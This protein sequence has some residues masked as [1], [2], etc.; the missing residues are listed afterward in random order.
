MFTQTRG[1]A[2][3][4]DQNQVL[5]TA[6]GGGTWRDVTP[7]DFISP[8]EGSTSY[9]L[10]PFFLDEST[11]WL[12]PFAV[13]V[14]TLYHT[15]D[16][17]QTWT[18]TSPPFENASFEFLDQNL[19]YALGDLGAGAGSH[20][21]AIYRTLDGGTTWTM[22]FTHEPGEIKSLP[23]GGSKNGITFRG[24]DH[25]W[26]GGAI[27]M[28]DYFYLHYT[29]DG[30]A[31]WAQETDIALPEEFSGSMLDVWQPVFLGASSAFLPVRAYP[32]GGGIYLLIFRSDD[33]DETWTYRGFVAGGEAVDFISVDEGWLAAGEDLFQTLDGSVTWSAVSATGIAV[34]EIFLKVDFVD[35]QNGW[36][37]TTPDSST[38]EPVKLYR[39][40]DGGESWSL[41]LP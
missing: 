27:P 35:Q 24:V 13:E 26:I 28:D 33:Y 6:D 5:V 21:V 38:W 37:L 12:M 7:P 30:G 18:M 20:F 9:W 41:L 36:V 32:P 1:W 39:T 22:V 4:R 40:V 25:G 14:G 17:G 31:T 10:R 15:R 16:G 3:T 11:A 19:G 23:N 29:D 2:V 8:P 34:D